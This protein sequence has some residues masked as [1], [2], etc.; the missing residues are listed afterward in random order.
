MH[1][2]TLAE[3]RKVISQN[4]NV[5]QHVAIIM[6]GNGRWAQQRG[7]PRIAGHQAGRKSVRQV[8]E[9][10]VD[11]GIPLLTLY[12]FSIENWQRPLDE[13]QALMEFLRQVLVEER[14][15]LKKNGVKLQAIGRLEDLPESVRNEL[16]T[17]RRFLEGGDRL[18]L[19]LA[20]SYGG[21]A[22]IVD[23]VRR[24]VDEVIKGRVKTDD[25]D[26]ELM[27]KHLYTKGMPHPDLLIR[28]SGELRLS[29][30][31]LWQ[32][33]YAE[34]WV[35]Q[36]LWPDFRKEDLFRAVVDYQKRNRRFGRVG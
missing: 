9:G 23:T 12:T 33:A 1:E 2:A 17:T 3:F 15:E 30:F 21:R 8:V 7:L 13:V 4:S 31:L 19:N 29:N 16:E 36:T 6:D 34:I 32:L 20:L 24:I 35:T 10:C 14:E 27:E 11:V 28:T 26:E 18:C 22:E 5:P 25:V